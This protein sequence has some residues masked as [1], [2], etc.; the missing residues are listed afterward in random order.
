MTKG[1]GSLEEE[2]LAQLEPDG[3]FTN[4]P[5][6]EKAEKISVKKGR[7]GESI[8]RQSKN[9]SIFQFQFACLYPQRN[10]VFSKF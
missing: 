6:E 3:S 4:F 5:V 8:L 10:L 7:K 9:L 1:F 2:D